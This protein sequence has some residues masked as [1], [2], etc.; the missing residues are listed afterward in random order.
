MLESILKSMIELKYTEQVNV[1][2]IEQVKRLLD[3][4]NDEP[5]TSKELMERVNL[6]HRP[7]FRDNYLL[8]AIEAGLVEMTIPDKPNSRNQKYRR[9]KN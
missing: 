1:Q 9:T 6:K 5:L 7:T 4:L 3:V 8:P 2:V